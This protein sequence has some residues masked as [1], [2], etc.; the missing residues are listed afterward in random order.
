MIKVIAGKYK[1]TNL[2]VSKNSSVRP[3]SSSIKESIFNIINSQYLKVKDANLFSD[4]IILD[5]FA[6]SGALGLEALS[7]GAKF[8]YF[9]EKDHKTNIN[10]KENCNKIL[11]NK[12]FKIINDDINNLIKED[13][14][15]IKTIDI[16]FFDPPY[17]YKY[18]DKTLVHLDSIGIL[19][20]DALIIV[21]T[22]YRNQPKESKYLKKMQE[23]IYG[24]TK[25]ILYKLCRNYDK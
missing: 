23:K 22:H 11:D 24:S 18:F 6:G 9:I 10:L 19:N 4:K 25:L 3:T 7:R 15:P 8:C 20:N 12:S 1:G 2:K 16:A 17:K 5:A 21:E 13:F 14:F